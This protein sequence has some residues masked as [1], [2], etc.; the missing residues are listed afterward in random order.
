[1]AIVNFQH[2]AYAS[3]EG[4]DLCSG[5]NNTLVHPEPDISNPMVTFIV[6]SG[7]MRV[8][9]DSGDRF[10][11]FSKTECNGTSGNLAVVVIRFAEPQQFVRLRT[12]SVTAGVDA[13]IFEFYREYN[14]VERLEM[15]SIPI[16][17][18]TDQDVTYS[19]SEPIKEVVIRNDL[20]DNRLLEVEFH[21]SLAAIRHDIALVLDGSG[22]MSAQ[23]KWGAMVQAAD[24]FHDLYSEFGSS[25]DQFGAVRFRCDCSDLLSGDQ[26]QEQPALS[27]LSVAVD[28][29]GLYAADGPDGCTPIGEGIIRGAEMVSDGT[30][31]ANHLFLMTD[32]KNNCGR[33]VLVACSD[34]KL[35]G[36]TVHTLGLGT[37]AHIDSAE[38][39]RVADDHHGDFRQTSNP[40]DVLDFFVE[41]LGDMLGK[42]ELANVTGDTVPIASGTSKAA[43][44]IAWDNPAD[45]H[46]FDLTAPGGEAVDHD[47]A[48]SI[49]GISWTYHPGTGTNAHAY[50][51]V[52]G[53]IAGNWRFRN[54]PGGDRILV[55]EDLDLRIQWL[56]NPQLGVTG[57]P[58]TL[59]ARITYQSR[60][61]AGDVTVKARVTRPDEARGDLVARELRKM[62]GS[63]KMGAAATPAGDTSRRAQIISAVLASYER[64]DYLYKALS[65]QLFQSEGEGVFC[66]QF[67]DTE[68]DGVYRFDLEAEGRDEQGSL[69]FARRATRFSTLLPN[70]DAG[71]TEIRVE[72]LENNL[73]RLLVTPMTSFGH[74]MGPFLADHLIISTTQGLPVGRLTDN[75]D[76]SYTQLIQTTG[77]VPDTFSIDVLGRVIPVGGKSGGRAGQLPWILVILLLILLLLA[78][79]L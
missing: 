44:L 75:L 32:G 13:T 62:Q 55:A 53:D 49:P 46:D 21:E 17:S 56:L 19:S 7:S 35:D 22:S 57:E 36:I 73:Y 4:I 60:P 16:V 47:S 45:S 72:A 52:E 43:F 28:I 77:V 51:V 6:A 50:F 38:I 18:G 66:L 20:V 58:I 41:T 8:G 15:R 5:T 30:N 25:A 78:L 10:L 68:N 9:S 48:P 39:T 59:E 79:V 2:S 64:Q 54:V 42:V 26:T 29:P 65:G 76:G 31:P 33:P 23:N 24:I 61:Y 37:E 34:A 3:I 63:R 74:F 14:R 11:F 67:T 1:M 12:G 27:P 71:K 40:A 69:V 70:I